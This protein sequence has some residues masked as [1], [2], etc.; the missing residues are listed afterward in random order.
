MDDSHLLSFHT[1]LCLLCSVQ[2]RDSQL[3]LWGRMSGLK[4]S[5][6]V[7]P[8]AGQRAFSHLTIGLLRDSKVFDNASFE[9]IVHEISRLLALMMKQKPP[10]GASPATTGVSLAASPS[11]GGTTAV[12][13]SL[14]EASIVPFSGPMQPL[15]DGD[16]VAVL[17]PCS[18]S[19][20]DDSGEAG[21]MDTRRELEV[22]MKS[23]G[24]ICEEKNKHSA[25][26]P[27]VAMED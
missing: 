10:P 1:T 26:V 11:T 17:P 9:H 6:E 7:R 22:L 2:V 18:K 12:S 19:G 4:Q 21:P 23:M 16:L 20:D 14:P 8:W 24:D 25:T 13:P 3:T 5:D 27:A 15:A